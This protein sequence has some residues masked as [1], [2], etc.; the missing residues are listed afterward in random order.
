MTF[1]SDP[2]YSPHLESYSLSTLLLPHHQ[3]NGWKSRTYCVQ[4]DARPSKR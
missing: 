3:L 1:K 2:P 4:I